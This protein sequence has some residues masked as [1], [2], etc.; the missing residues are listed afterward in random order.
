VNTQSAVFKK[1]AEFVG[2]A[3]R[4]GGP[5]TITSLKAEIRQAL[6]SDPLLL[7]IEGPEVG[8]LWDAE[9]PFRREFNH[10]VMSVKEWR[11]RY[12]LPNKKTVESV[13][14]ILWDE[15]ERVLIERLKDGIRVGMP[16]TGGVLCFV[17]GSSKCIVFDYAFHG[18][19]AEIRP[20]AVIDKPQSLFDF[21]R[22]IERVHDPAAQNA[23]KQILASGHKVVFQRG[24]LVHVD[25]REDIGVFGPSID[26]LVLAEL[27]VQLLFE[28][29]ARITTALEIGS[30]SGL[31]SA[32][33]LRHGSTLDTVLATDI[34]FSSVAC[35][36]KNCLSSVPLHSKCRRIFLNA[37]F[38]PDL[39][40]SK[41][42]LC[43]CNPPYVPLPPSRRQNLGRPG[44]AANRRATGGAELLSKLLMATDRIL[45][46]TGAMLVMTS[47]L[48]RPNTY[49]CLP[50]DK[51]DVTR[52]LGEDGLRVIF[53]VDSVV[54]DTE[55]LG[56]LLEHC[57]LEEASGVYYH[58]LH[59]LLLTR[60]SA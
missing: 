25:R 56:Y 11:R 33:M 30:G 38:E 55:W 29:Q 48:T 40:P 50:P 1:A 46:Q 7:A 60:R 14:F 49:E 16:R 2:M 41:Y 39:L 28:G 35:T 59:P 42:D 10:W 21:W 5:D 36:H 19:V 37:A 53:D 6:Y 20:I 31:L 9:D 54:T 32:M 8:R 4:G 51:F 43:V 17:G 52:P 12:L 57:G 26:T 15:F 3:L 13:L 47:N 58:R 22:T 24:V 18:K 23:L 45:T 44:F 34:D 27:M